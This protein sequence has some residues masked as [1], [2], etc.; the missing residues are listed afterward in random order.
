[1]LS[2]EEAYTHVVCSINPGNNAM[3]VFIGLEETYG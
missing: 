3:R 1:M 2:R